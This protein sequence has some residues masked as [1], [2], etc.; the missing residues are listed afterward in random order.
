MIRYP[1]QDLFFLILLISGSLSITTKFWEEEVK[2]LSFKE[3]L[4]LI[5]L[6]VGLL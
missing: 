2:L 6:K 1:A 3:I 5:E 4:P